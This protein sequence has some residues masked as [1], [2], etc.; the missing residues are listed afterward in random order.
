M[1]VAGPASQVTLA[2]V[3]QQTYKLNYESLRGCEIG[4]FEDGG[5]EK[6]AIKFTGFVG[7]TLLHSLCQL[8]P[9]L[10][11]HLDL[12]NIGIPGTMAVSRGSSRQMNRTSKIPA[13]HNVQPLRLVFH[14][15]HPHAV[16]NHPKGGLRRAIH[17][18]QTWSA[19]HDSVVERI[20]R[21]IASLSEDDPVQTDYNRAF[22][23]VSETDRLERK[24][25]VLPRCKEGDS[26]SAG[27][28]RSE[29][30]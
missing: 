13:C 8:P 4:G 29:W 22:H 24:V 25:I 30:R 1:T 21:A 5:F 15:P 19:L 2:A 27:H 14:G 11:S 16:L 18:I 26:S 12:H 17:R 3:I 28:Q 6:K 9:H 10:H 7:I 20:E 23:R